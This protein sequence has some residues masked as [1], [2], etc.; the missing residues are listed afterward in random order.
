M[1]HEGGSWVVRATV[2]MQGGSVAWC[3]GRDGGLSLLPCRDGFRSARLV[4]EGRVLEAGVAVVAV[5]LPADG[6]NG[7]PPVDLVGVARVIGPGGKGFGV[8]WRAQAGGARAV[9]LW[10]GGSWTG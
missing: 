7:F 4:H 6:V 5:A 1:R 8:G 3:R 2:P 9:G 10:A